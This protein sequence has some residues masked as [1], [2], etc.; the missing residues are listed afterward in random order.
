[1]NP[2]LQRHWFKLVITIVFFAIVASL[3]VQLNGG[4]ESMPV[5]RQAADFQL[6]DA[7]GSRVALSDYGGKV[8]IVYFFF[9]SCPDVCYPTNHILSGVQKEL[10]KAG[11]FGSDAMIFSISFDPAR[12]TPERLKEYAGSLE[13]DPAAWKFLRGEEQATADLAE[14]YGVSV[15]KANDGN[16]I[17]SNIITLVDREGNIRKHISAADLKVTPA[18]IAKSVRQLVEEPAP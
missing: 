1:M 7:D 9:G 5:I 11:V 10:V 14:Q 6:E 8:R 12:D 16:F 18:E 3:F 2:F 17:H 15:L 13:A 4:K